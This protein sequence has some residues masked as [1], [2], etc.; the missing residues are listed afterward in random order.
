MLDGTVIAG[1]SQ[2]KVGDHVTKGGLNVDTVWTTLAAVVVVLGL[3]FYMA[4]RASIGR[5]S[6]IQVAWEGIFGYIGDLV[7]QNMGP[8][9]RKVVPLGVTMFALVLV[10][11]WVEILPGLFHNTDFLPSP[12]ADVN[13]CYALAA[14]VLIVTNVAALRA[15]GLK[16]FFTRFFAKPRFLFPIRLIEEI[17]NPISLALRLFGNLFAGGIMIQL[18]IA[19]PIYAF[20]PS[21]G[22]TVVWKLFDMF[23]GVVQA[24]IFALLTILYYQFAVDTSAH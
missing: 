8:E 4:N 18:L 22:F 3:G 17:A 13:L 23:I 7:E 16:G 2:I 1:L 9:Y 21:I 15:R 10:A 19:F 20:V 6:K 14:V 11:N 5:P 24:F 12:T